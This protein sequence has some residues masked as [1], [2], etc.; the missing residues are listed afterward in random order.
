MGL[1]DAP[2]SAGRI[3]SLATA[4]VTE[5]GLRSQL[6]SL[7]LVAWT[8]LAL[9][10]GIIL[11][12]AV[13]LNTTLCLLLVPV[14]LLA[15]GLLNQNSGQHLQTACLLVAVVVCGSVRWQITQPLPGQPQLNSIAAGESR[16][17]RVKAVIATVPVLR[18]GSDESLFSGRLDALDQ[19][20]FL[21]DITPLSMEN[22]SGSSGLPITGRC[23]VY[24]Q[25]DASKS[26]S[27]GDEV[28]L[29]GEYQ[30]PKSPGNP[31]EFD[32][33][34]YLR[35]HSLQGLFFVRHHLTIQTVRPVPPWHPNA[36][37]SALRRE[38]RHALDSSVDA[39]V[40]PIALAL[41]LG[42]RHMLPAE[43]E[44]SFVASGTMHLLAISGL[45]VGILCGFLMKVLHLLMV[46]RRT[47]LILTGCVC[48]TYALMT[49]LR[50]SVLR[51]TVFFLVFAVS[52]FTQR[53]ISIS[54]LLGFTA[55]IMLSLQPMMAFDAGA[56]LSFLSVAALGMLGSRLPPPD[57]RRS[58]PVEHLTMGERLAELSKMLLS[59]ISHR[60]LQMLVVL[61]VTSPLVAMTFHV[62]SPIALVVNLVLIA[63][64]VVALWFGIA[65]LFVGFLWPPL[66]AVPGWIFSMLLQVLASGVS[67]AAAVPGGHLFL[68]HPP[69]WLIPAYYALLTL[70]LFGRRSRLPAT[71][72]LFAVVALALI[73]S[74][75]QPTDSDVTVTVLDVGHGSAAVVE[76]QGHAFLIDAG[77]MNGGDKTADVICRFLW[78]RGIRQLNGLLVSHADIDH[79][80]AVPGILARMP[81]A[82]LVTSR[83]FVR[84]DAQPVQSLL[85]LADRHRVPI[86]LVQHRDSCRLNDAHLTILSPTA[87][88]LPSNAGDNERSLVVSMSAFGR[89]VLATG[90][91][92]GAGLNDLLPQLNSADILISPHHGAINSNTPSLA[93]TV[94]PQIV[95]V[96]ARDTH[97]RPVLENV[98]AQARQVLF[99]G[100][101]GAIQFRIQPDGTQ[102]SSGFRQSSTA[103][104]PPRS[105]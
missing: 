83:D 103:A 25:G 99:T 52:E 11:A 68:A 98:Y 92:E 66:T 13:P 101:V 100:D 91:I 36:W 86:R 43:V 14:W 42:N 51:A 62:V 2:N 4:L 7:P 58:V 89:R 60:T 8:A 1:S 46:R 96:S 95:A 70:A 71:A 26:L 35:R 41:L 20:R 31:G 56:W 28:I 63:V 38:A 44:G 67:W 34:Q 65:V 90:D 5:S 45:H 93:A 54:G 40:R 72:G 79:Y 49:D 47:A 77:A 97:A 88:Q 23:M 102:H 50:P 84:S 15:A 22:D 21:A 75:R 85:H 9:L 30:W 33:Q 3:Y 17:M 80:G 104:R 24:V 29:T 81:V 53:R 74:P 57:F 105:L 82:E 78:S 39:R 94:Q 19:T 32:F 55:L 27:R 12:E 64:T 10:L 69:V 87:D 18:A 16:V 76:S 37:I 48:V 59:H 61:M 6:A 73:D